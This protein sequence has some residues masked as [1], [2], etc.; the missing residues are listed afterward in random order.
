MACGGD[1]LFE[2]KV[3]DF[4]IKEDTVTGVTTADGAIFQGDSFILATGH[5]ARD[6]FELLHAKKILIESKSSNDKAL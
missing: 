4:I 3:V 1:Y 2:K 5:S 6:I